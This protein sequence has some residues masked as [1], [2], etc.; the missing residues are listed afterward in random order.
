[1]A[2]CTF[3]GSE[4]LHSAGCS[5]E[6]LRVGGVDYEPIR[7][8]DEKG[9]RFG[10]VTDRCGD[11]GV[12]KGAVH[13]HGCDLEQ[14]PVCLSQALSCGCLD[15]CRPRVRPATDGTERRAS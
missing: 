11:C 1:V 7:W 6:T 4:M 12:P 9:Y 5:G 2:I 14:C 3:C 8:G 13:H 15:G 10:Y